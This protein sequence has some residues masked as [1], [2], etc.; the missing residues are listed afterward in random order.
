[1]R[2]DRQPPGVGAGEV[3]QVVEQPHQMA[4][5]VEDHPDRLDLARV[6]LFAFEH[7]QLGEALDRGEGAAELGARR[8]ARTRL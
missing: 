7:Q 8:S 1:L 4:G 6:R 5:V 3:E 2:P